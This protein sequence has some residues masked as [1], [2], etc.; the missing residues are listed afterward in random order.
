MTLR[1]FSADEILGSIW[2]D[3]M[4]VGKRIASIFFNTRRQGDTTEMYHDV[5]IDVEMIECLFHFR[6]GFDVFFVSLPYIIHHPLWP[7]DCCKIEALACSH[8]F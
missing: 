7:S 8:P 4:T 5:Y 1:F 2:C 6:C 3:S